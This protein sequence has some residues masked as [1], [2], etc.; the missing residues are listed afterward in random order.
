MPQEDTL[1]S[2]A[3]LVLR[4]G[5]AGLFLWFGISQIM[6][7]AE[8][9][10]W[11]PTW[12]PDFSGMDAQTIVLLNGGFEV[13]GGILL[14]FGLFVRWAALFLG[15]HLLVIAY[16][17]GYNDIG[18]RDAALAVSCFSMSLFGADAWSLDRKLSIQWPFRA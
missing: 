13:V 16:E 14:L 8:W 2:F 6:A 18:I 12:V 3:P 7:P 15:F 11:V 10:A 4:L 9:I 17:V 1:R 5:L